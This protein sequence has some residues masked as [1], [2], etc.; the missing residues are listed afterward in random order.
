MIATMIRCAAL[1]LLFASVP[2]QAGNAE[3]GQEK[4]VVCQACHGPDGNGVGDPQYPIIA[5]QYADYLVH[6]MRSYKTGE[7]SDLIMQGFM[8]TLSEQDIADLAAWYASQQGP[9]TDIT[10][11]IR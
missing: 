8:A 9:L 11:I 10:G 6:A 7:R 1:A 3:R 5:G 2:A 4:S